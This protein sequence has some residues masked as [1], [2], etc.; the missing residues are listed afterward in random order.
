MINAKCCRLTTSSALSSL[1]MPQS[2]T[3]STILSVPQGN[4]SPS[5]THKVKT[6]CM[7]ADLFVWQLFLDVDFNYSWECQVALNRSN[8]SYAGTFFSWYHCYRWFSSPYVLRDTHSLLCWPSNSD[9]HH[10]TCICC[11]HVWE[12]ILWTAIYCDLCACSGPVH[13]SMMTKP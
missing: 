7:F 13:V 9:I 6:T 5:N 4:V 11:T 1:V 12:K 3:P 2:S 8:L 10:L